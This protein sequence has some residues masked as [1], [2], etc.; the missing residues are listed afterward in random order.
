MRYALIAVLTAAIVGGLSWLMRRARPLAADAHS[1]AIRPGRISAVLTVLGGLAFTAVGVIA[2][3]GGAIPSA[4]AFLAIGVPITV[5]MAPSLTDLHIVHWDERGLEG[6]S[7]M[8][9]LTLGLAR[10][11]LAWK[12]LR[13]AGKTLTGYW[14]AEAADGRRVYWSYLYPGYGALVDAIVGQRPDLELPEDLQ[15]SRA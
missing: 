10:T 12:D 14:Y 5:F 8:F 15:P 4:L 2:L 3:I 7:R 1:G 9:G 11:T 13:C 6:P